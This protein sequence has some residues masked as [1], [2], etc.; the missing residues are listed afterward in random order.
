MKRIHRVLVLIPLMLVL[1][2]SLV[3]GKKRLE[4]TIF[5]PVEIDHPL[6]AALLD[7]PVMERLKGISQHGTPFYFLNMPAFN[8]YEHSVGVYALVRSVGAPFEE[9]V[10]GLLHD[11]SHTVFSHTADYLFKPKK[12]G[13]SY[14]DEIHEWYLNQMNLAPLLEKYG[15]SVQDI[16]AK[17]PRF[18]AL[19]QPLPDLCA[20]R[21]QYLLQTAM[22]FDLMDLNEVQKIRNDL[23]FEKGRWYFTTLSSAKKLGLLSLYFTRHFYTSPWNL[24]VNTKSAQMFSRALKMGLLTKEEIHFGRDIPVLGKLLRSKDPTI[25]SLIQVC[26]HPWNHYTVVDVAPYDDFYIPKFRGVDPLVLYQGRL[27]RLTSL[28]YI[29]RQQYR[30]LKETLRRGIRLKQHAV[31]L[32][33]SEEAQ[34]RS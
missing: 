24:F 17:N 23:R 3:E 25:L 12:Q 15:L 28:D 20:D 26:L 34:R 29:Y 4:S 7:A 31:P 14:Q 1:S 21:I 27:R 9:Q 16:L 18:Q 33:E 30:N 19:E 6:I 13:E 22:I 10:A 11:A 8:R 32:K 2:L 5:G